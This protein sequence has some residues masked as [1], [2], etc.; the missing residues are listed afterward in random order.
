MPLAHSHLNSHFQLS[1]T[2]QAAKKLRPWPCCNSCGGCTKSIPPQCQCRD[3]VRSCH[4]M[5]QN[6]VKSPLSA[7]PPLYQC[8]DRIPNYCKYSCGSVLNQ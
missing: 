8:M 3:L 5:C 6:C 2:S 4:P 1:G 7:D